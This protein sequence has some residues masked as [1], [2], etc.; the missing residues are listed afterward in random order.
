MTIATVSRKKKPFNPLEFPLENKMTMPH[1]IAAALHWL[2]ENYPYEFK[3]WTVIYQMVMGQT[4][5]PKASNLEVIHLKDRT[6]AVKRIL[7]ERYN[8]G[9]ITMTQV[10]VRASVDDGDRAKY[11]VTKAISRHLATARSVK[12][13]I[14]AVDAKKIPDTPEMRSVKQFMTQ[15]GKATLNNINDTIRRTLLLVAKKD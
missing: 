14:E 9:I 15:E 8:R 13:E 2:A 3:P 10:G 7:N 1:R 6:Q 12:R 4:V 5:L 11:C